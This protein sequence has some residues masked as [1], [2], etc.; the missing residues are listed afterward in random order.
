MPGPFRSIAIWASQKPE[1]SNFVISLVALA[2]VIIVVGAVA[3]M[4]WATAP[5]RRPEAS[6]PGD[7]SPFHVGFLFSTYARTPSTRSSLV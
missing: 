6:L 4:V 1:R 7:Q 5:Q 3:G 2:M